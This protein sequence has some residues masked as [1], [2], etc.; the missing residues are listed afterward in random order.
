MNTVRATYLVVTVAAMAFT[1]GCGGRSSDVSASDITTATGGTT[2]I[3]GSGGALSLGTGGT[4][5]DGGA[6]GCT[7]R[8]ETY[9]LSTE[10]PVQTRDA[11]LLPQCTPTCGAAYDVQPG[12]VPTVQALP[13]GPCSSEPE[14]LMAATPC[15]CGGN[16]SG[17]LCTCAD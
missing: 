6:A 17:Y 4:S 14:C 7:S 15:A 16:V 12:G 1:C 10:F 2:V 13:A 8:S 9:S 3:R 5:A 11:E